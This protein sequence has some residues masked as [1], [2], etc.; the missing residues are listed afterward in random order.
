MVAAR[1]Q[2]E[3]HHEREDLATLEKMKS[4]L[5]SYNF[6]GQYQQSPAPQGGGMIKEQWFKTYTPES[7]PEPFDY[8]LQSWDTANKI[9][10]LRACATISMQFVV[11]L[12]QLKIAAF[13]A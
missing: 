4:N 12:S 13:L 7:C 2:E 11:K 8:I 9:T 10:E 3:L 6:A 5:G 1:M